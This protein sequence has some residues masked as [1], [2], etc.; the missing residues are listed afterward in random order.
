MIKATRN[1]WDYENILV[2]WYKLRNRSRT[3]TVT[4]SFFF[5]IKRLG[6]KL[7]HLKHMIL[8]IFFLC[9]FITKEE[10]CIIMGKQHKMVAC[11]CLSSAVLC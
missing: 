5:V 3:G 1:Q 6:G 4:R 11:I 9:F 7:K 10:I 8:D 2:V